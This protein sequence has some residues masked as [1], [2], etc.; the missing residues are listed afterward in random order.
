MV[1]W[2][3]IDREV[4]RERASSAEYRKKTEGRPLRSDAR[5]L[6]DQELLA[7]LRSLGVEMDA[8][9]LGRLCDDS[10]SAQEIAEPL[11]EQYVSGRNRQGFESDWI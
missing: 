9:A 4:E 10:L 6:S 7:K 1:S 2:V 11:I 3:A 5:L 8:P